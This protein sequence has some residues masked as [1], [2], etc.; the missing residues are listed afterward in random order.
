MRSQTRA[1]PRVSCQPWELAARA[2]SSASGHA[3]I[4]RFSLT[5]VAWVLTGCPAVDDGGNEDAAS[6]DLCADV[7]CGD[8]GHCEQTGP[9]AACVC[10]DGYAGSICDACASGYLEQ[11]ASSGT[12]IEDTCETAGTCTECI[13][14][15]RW[16][17]HISTDPVTDA[18]VC[19]LMDWQLEIDGY[20]FSSMFW[21]E[22]DS[23]QTGLTSCHYLQ[24]HYDTWCCVY[25]RHAGT[26]G[27]CVDGRE[28]RYGTCSDPPVIPWV[29]GNVLYSRTA[30][31]TA[32]DDYYFEPDGSRKP[33][34]QTRAFPHPEYF[35]VADAQRFNC[36]A[37][38]RMTDVETGI[39]V[40]VYAEDGGPK[41]IHE[42]IVGADDGGRRIIDSSPAVL[43]YLRPRAM[44]WHPGATLFLLEW[45]LADDVPGQ[46]CVPC[47][48][49]AASRGSESRRT[50][51]DCN[52]AISSD[53][54]GTVDPP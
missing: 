20:Y 53:C 49:L 34:D 30:L 11:P 32:V 35:Y 43:R 3:L 6:V 23:G 10:D 40:V 36:G 45:G 14:P 19:D 22:P 2:R 31:E 5:L 52:H 26:A 39:C 13:D 46:S 15:S 50:P 21:I 27:A 9:A 16:P 47:Q 42:M 48:S 17:A 25:D 44:G 37:T 4:G 38:L 51:Y 1:S 18:S 24:E 12:C 28:P 54:R 41:G 8:H 29:T 7:A 33:A